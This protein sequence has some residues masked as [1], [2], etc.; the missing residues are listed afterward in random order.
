MKTICNI[1]IVS[2]NFNHKT[3]WS[4]DAQQTSLCKTSYKTCEVDIDFMVTFPNRPLQP[5]SQLL[6]EMADIEE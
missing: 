6:F 5:Q 4:M 2:R 3:E 1:D